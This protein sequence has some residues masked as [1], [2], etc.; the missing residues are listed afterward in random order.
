MGRLTPISERWHEAKAGAV[1]GARL[2]RNGVNEN[3]ASD[4]EVGVNEGDGLPS[5]VEKAKR[6]TPSGIVGSK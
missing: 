6:L 3:G 5:I 2:A 1:Q 4:T